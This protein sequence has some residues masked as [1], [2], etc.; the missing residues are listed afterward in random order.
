MAATTMYPEASAFRDAV[1]GRVVAMLSTKDD[2]P[3]TVVRTL[4]N[5]LDAAPVR[6]RA[7]LPPPPARSAA[8]SMTAHVGV[9]AIVLGVLAVVLWGAGGTSSDYDDDCTDD[10][11]DDEE[12]E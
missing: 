10:D 1:C 7:G 5:A 12:D 2:T 4:T 3:D 11:D 6:R 8:M 9:L